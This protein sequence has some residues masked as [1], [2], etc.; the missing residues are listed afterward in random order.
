VKNLLQV[1]ICGITTV[2]QGVAIA[3]LG[4]TALGYICVQKSP[5]YIAPEGIAPITAAV[6]TLDSSLEHF[7]VFA[8]SPLAEVIEVTRK[9]ALTV[10]QLHGDETPATCA[11]LRE[12]L[13]YSNL[14]TVKLVKALRIRTPE[15]LKIAL[16]Y[17]PYID[18]LLLDAYHPDQL[19]GT[20]KTLD[21]QTLKDF[22]PQRPWF[23]AGGLTPDNVRS[24]L[25]QLSPSGIDLSSGVE[26]SPGDKDLLKVA[27]LF[28]QL[29]A[30]SQPNT[31][32]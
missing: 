30:F 5:R 20:G 14:P 26:R 24:A 15:D 2:A 7:G 18:T 13:A 8:N 31:Y 6:T 28:E 32:S 16:S 17:E 3:Q 1:K 12:A 21:W 19:G 10:I 11:L 25:D 4:A 29:K 9:A 22:S 23:L 27:Q